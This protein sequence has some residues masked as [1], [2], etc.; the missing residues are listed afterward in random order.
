MTAGAVGSRFVYLVTEVCAGGT[1]T[2]LCKEIFCEITG[3]GEE[4]GGVAR[5]GSGRTYVVMLQDSQHVL[6]KVGLSGLLKRTLQPEAMCGLKR[7]IRGGRA[8]PP[9]A[10]LPPAL[11]EG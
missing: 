1:L 11:A 5:V 4:G 8:P 3:E 7:A 10:R 9:Q 6:L 2:P